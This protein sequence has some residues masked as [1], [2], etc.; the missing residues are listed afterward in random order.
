MFGSKKKIESMEKYEKDIKSLKEEIKELKEESKQN[1]KVLK[2]ISKHL[3]SLSQGQ[4]N[5]IETSDKASKTIEEKSESF[6]R[7]IRKLEQT[8]LQIEQK[9]FS[10]ISSTIEGELSK[11]K[12]DAEKYNALKEELAQI[13]KTLDIL[14]TNI[15]NFNVIAARIKE[16]DFE[17]VNYTEKFEKT[18]REKNKIA[19]E[20]ERLKDIMAK[21]AKQ[22]G[23]YRP[24]R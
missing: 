23:N 15:S 9:T 24:G 20:C 22:R 7:I 6:D 3:I 8:N 16:K 21:M 19:E 12:T 17:L 14:R 18:E 2:E 13:T 4:N 1:S 11:I 10:K 5:I